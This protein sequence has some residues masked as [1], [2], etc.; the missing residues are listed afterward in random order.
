MIQKIRRRFIAV[1]MTALFI[2]LAAI[3]TGMNIF[4][5][6]LVIQGADNKLELLSQN[7]GIF[8]EFGTAAAPDA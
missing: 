8:P 1:A 3:V 4:N 5:F 2:L 6:N 7:Q